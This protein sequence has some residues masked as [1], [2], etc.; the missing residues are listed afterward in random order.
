M[1]NN[2]L[3]AEKS[4]SGHSCLARLKCF[5]HLR[6]K[7]RGHDGAADHYVSDMRKTL[8]FTVRGNAYEVAG[9]DCGK[10]S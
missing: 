7:E 3:T 4:K 5:V 10:A 9:D 2:H 1:P 6:G 8:Q